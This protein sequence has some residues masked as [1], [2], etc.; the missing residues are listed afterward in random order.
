[1]KKWAKKI[2]K[3]TAL[4]AGVTAGVL[5][6]LITA[7]FIFMNIDKKEETKEAVVP[8]TGPSSEVTETGSIDVGT[9]VQSFVLDISEVTGDSSFS[10]DGG[11]MEMMSFQMPGSV[12]SGSSSSSSSGTRQLEIEE[13]YVEAGQEIKEGEAILKLTA[14]SAESIRSKLEEDVTQAKIVYDQTVTMQKQSLTEAESLLKTNTLYGSYAQSEW[15]QKKDTL[16]D[17]AAAAQETLTEAEE[18][19]EDAKTEYEEKQALLAEEEKVL[20]N[21]EYTA[22][23]TDREEALYWWVIAWQTKEETKSLIT[24]LKEELEALEESIAEYEKEAASARRKLT[25][26]EGDLEKGMAEADILLSSRSYS[27]ENA[28]EIY[29]VSV[30]QSEFDAES[31]KKDY[32]EAK[33]KLEDFDGVIA[34]QVIYADYNGLITEVSVAAGDTLT[35]NMDLVTLNDYDEVTITLSI[36]EEDREA[37]ALGNKAEIT[38]AAFPDMVF[39]GEVTEIGDAE[40][41]SNT[42]KTMYTVI[43]SVKNT[44]NLLYQDMTAEVAFITEASEEGGKS[45]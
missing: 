31:A 14:D 40:I 6:L 30:A 22:E 15:Q 2:N 24:S 3:K 10:W 9:T 7:L 41:D 43:V 23:G 12:S 44:D 21:A 19:L 35:Q 16:E 37:A 32:E 39:E 17:A 36:E 20:A 1:M 38:L 27:Y 34:E 4:A 13:V 5:L 8:E 26:A 29:D 11:G 18:A 45:S 28:R 42:N 33:E 25:L